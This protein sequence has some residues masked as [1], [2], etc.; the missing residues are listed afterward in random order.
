MAEMK[1]LP[2]NVAVWE[3]KPNEIYLESSEAELF[4]IEFLDFLKVLEFGAKKYSPNGWLL[5]DP[6]EA[7]FERDKN[8]ASVDR[9]IKE[10]RSGVEAD[11]ETGLDPL[12]H[13]ICRLQMEYTRKK[14]GLVY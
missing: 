4:H 11:W 14:K 5:P 13:T 1:P 12:L 2:I 10:T 7:K 6:K 3:F 9:H 8:N